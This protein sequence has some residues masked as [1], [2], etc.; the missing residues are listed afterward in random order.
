M[1]RFPS[2]SLSI[3]WWETFAAIPISLNGLGL[4][5]G[6]YVVLLS[7]IGIGTEKAIAFGILLF[8]VVACDS[9]IGGVIYLFQ[10]SASRGEELRMRALANEVLTEKSY[11]TEKRQESKGIGKPCDDYAGAEGR[12][13]FQRF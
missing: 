4:R 5:E 10:Q 13:E 9:L 6:G 12:I 1:C 11:E 2:R 8:L 3:H 7:A